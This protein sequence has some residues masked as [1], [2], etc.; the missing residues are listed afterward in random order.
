MGTQWIEY[1]KLLNNLISI[2]VLITRLIGKGHECMSESASSSFQSSKKKNKC[3]IYSDPLRSAAY[4]L[5][6]AGLMGP[7]ISS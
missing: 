3:N 1:L 4:K 7:I 2:I 6:A 5:Y